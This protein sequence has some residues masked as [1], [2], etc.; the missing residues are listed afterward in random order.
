MGTGDVTAAV[1]SAAQD[2]VA[3]TARGR[4]NGLVVLVASAGWVCWAGGHQRAGNGREGQCLAEEASHQ[5][6]CGPWMDI[7]T[8]KKEWTEPVGSEDGPSEREDAMERTSAR[9][10]E[11]GKGQRGPSSENIISSIVTA[12]DRA[13]GSLLVGAEGPESDSDPARL[14]LQGVNTHY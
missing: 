13:A 14:G 12:V 6:E 3:V 5:K 1:V 2:L 4:V 7:N 9:F 8:A 11:K 10:G